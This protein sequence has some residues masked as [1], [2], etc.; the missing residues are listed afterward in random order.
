MDV[1][2]PT[3]IKV[4]DSWK[5]Q[6]QVTLVSSSKNFNYSSTATFIYAVPGQ[7]SPIQSTGGTT[8]PMLTCAPKTTPMPAPRRTEASRSTLKSTLKLSEAFT[9]TPNST[10]GLTRAST[11]TSQF[12][13]GAHAS[14][15][16]VFQ[17]RAEADRSLHVDFQI[18]RRFD[19]SNLTTPSF[20]LNQII[21]K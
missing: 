9:W 10:P 17:F 7:F 4:S 8:L 2:L 18:P 16:V 11:R 20:E 15:H 14:P 19:L 5:G 13:A 3:S 12:H 21:S 6:V 1:W